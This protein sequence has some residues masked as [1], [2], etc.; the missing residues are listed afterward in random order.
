MQLTYKL[1]EDNRTRII[2]GLEHSV[3][4]QGKHWIWSRQLQHNLTY[5]SETFENALLASVASLLYTIE[6][7][8]E[9]IE[10]LQRIADLAS[11]FADQIKP[12]CQEDQ[13]FLNSYR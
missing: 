10:N 2:E 5:K 8:D 13:D 3:D 11:V 7:K 1:S 4:K 9:R 12:D 6:L